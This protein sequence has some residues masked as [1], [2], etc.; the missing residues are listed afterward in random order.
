MAT[1]IA[2]ER[3]TSEHRVQIKIFA[4]PG[5][6]FSNSHDSQPADE[7]GDADDENRR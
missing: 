7:V 3:L 4:T 2:V 5:T 1:A 6:I